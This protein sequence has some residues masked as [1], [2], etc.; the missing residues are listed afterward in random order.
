MRLNIFT[1]LFLVLFL[2][3]L[4]IL[5]AAM[6]SVQWSFRRGFD[7]Y[8]EQVDIRRMDRLADLLASAYEAEGGW[9]FLRDNQERWFAILREARD[10]A[11]ERPGP[12]GP[13][14]PEH[15]P[16]DL[17]PPP[18]PGPGFPEPP[19]PPGADF[20][21]P[22]PRHGPHPRGPPGRFGLFRNGHLRVLDDSKAL[23]VGPPFGLAPEEL[24]REI[25]RPIR[26]GSA[27]VG[28]LGFSRH[29]GTF[30]DELE[31]AFIRENTRANVLILLLVLLAALAASLLLARLFLGPIRRLAAGARDL[32][33][34]RYDVE[35]PA[36]GG[37]ELGRLAQDF[38]AL[39][40]TL[41]RNEEARRQW[42]ADT[43][44]EMRT[45]LA[46]LRS[47]VEAL[48]DGVR[49]PTP[50]RLKS[51]HAEILGM[52]KLVDDLYELSVYDL[53]AIRFRM[54]TLDLAELARETADSFRPRFEAAGLRLEEAFSANPGVEITGDASRLRQLLGN[55]LENSLRYT[56]AGGLCRLAVRKAGGQAVLDVEDSAPG[57]P[58]E[59]L[60]RLFERFF[61]TDKS[62]SRARGGAGLGLAIC[63]NIAEAHGGVLTAAH[64]PLGGLRVRLELPAAD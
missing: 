29:P 26:A 33:A 28:W 53:G 55:L 47:E 35:I 50:E 58:D 13:A 7:G 57:V 48:L 16:P 40:R 63:R 8:L 37:D 51:L 38:N 6:A 15:P 49:Q 30:G 64:S 60:G 41:Q 2:S 45:P 42:V 36:S 9:E 24:A 25:L 54:E 17:G 1:K 32:A 52:G 34:G 21:G 39:A 11:G 20:G 3:L 61:R 31:A 62:R 19:P 27:T 43:S 44:H 5:A 12:P 22:P 59:A 10:R 14:G 18:L 56:D 46:V 4:L 23:V